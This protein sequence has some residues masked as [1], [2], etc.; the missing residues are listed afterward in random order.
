MADEQLYT[1]E[2]IKAMGY[3]GD[4]VSSIGGKYKLSQFTG[5]SSGGTTLP[6]VNTVFDDPAKLNEYLSGYQGEVLKSLGLGDAIGADGKVSYS[7]IDSALTPNTDMP[8]PINRAENFNVLKGEYG[9]APLESELNDLKAQA[10][11]IT[12]QLRINKTSERGKAVAQ[13]IVEGR[14]GEQERNAQEEL[15]YIGRRQSR[16]TDQLNTA[17]KAIDMF[18]NF[19]SLDYADAVDRY[20]TEF[21]QNMQ[22][23]GMIQSTRSEGITVASKMT[24]VQFQKANLE[25]QYQQEARANLQIMANAITSGNVDPTTL[26]ADQKLAMN[27]LEI[28]SG[29][30]IGFTASLG[31]SAKDKIISSSTSNGVTSVIISDAS[32]NLSVKKVG[33]PTGGTGTGATEKALEADLA[34]K[35][36]VDEMFAKYGSKLSPDYLI[37]KYDALSPNGVH[38]ESAQQLKDQYNVQSPKAETTVS[39]ADINKAVQLARKNGASDSEIQAIQSDPNKYVNDILSLYGDDAK[40]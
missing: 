37:K 12:A 10:D 39:N 7:A 16:V 20:K 24:D 17:Y 22:V 8:G 40:L 36:G 27:K 33:T 34:T 26:S 14:I 13:N 32:G 38:K 6:S 1:G 25:I 3:N 9:V 23:L 5:G 29:L 15:D 35:M 4:T 19:S 28:Q 31:L 18:M 30:P 21:T 2:E 11:E